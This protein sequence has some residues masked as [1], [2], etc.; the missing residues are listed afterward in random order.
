MGY[1]RWKQFIYI[2]IGSFF[3]SAGVS[4]FLDPNEIAPGGFIGLSVI[5]SHTIGGETGTWYLLLNIPIIMIGLKVFGKRFILKSFFAIVLNSFLTNLLVGFD[6][7][8]NDLLLASIAGSILVGTGLG[9]ILKVGATTGGVDIIVRLIRIKYPGMKISTLFIIIDMIIV[10]ISGIVFRD[11]NI[12]MFALITVGL[13]G[14]VMDYILYGSDE[15]KLIYIISDVPGKVLKRI[16]SDMEVGATIL[17]GQGAYSNKDKEII[18]CV[19]KKRKS[20]LLQNIVKEEDEKAFMIITN[21]NEIYGE[22]Y[23]SLIKP[24]I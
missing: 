2:L 6:A 7:I 16:F 24:D 9:L 11:F 10:T 13:N 23:K 21:A 14:R 19:V 18:M 5:L 8:T 17:S 20:I 22:G 4:L 15:A 1:T 3:Y 12:A